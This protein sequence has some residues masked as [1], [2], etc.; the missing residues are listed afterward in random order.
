MG[1]RSVLAVCDEEL[2]RLRSANRGWNI[3]FVPCTQPGGDLRIVWCAQPKPLLNCHSPGELTAE[4]RAADRWRPGL[5]GE[6]AR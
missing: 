2:A 3:W 5:A 6:E 4:M 1:S